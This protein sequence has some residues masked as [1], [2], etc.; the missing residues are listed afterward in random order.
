[1]TSKTVTNIN[2]K[3]NNVFHNKGDTFINNTRYREKGNTNTKINGRYEKKKVRYTEKE[4]TSNYKQQQ[5]KQK[6]D[7][8]EDDL[9]ALTFHSN[10][11]EEEE[12]EE[13]IIRRRDNR[14]LI[15]E[16]SVLAS[17][18]P[19]SNYKSFNIFSPRICVLTE[20]MRIVVQTL[21]EIH[22]KSSTDFRNSIR[23]KK[24]FFP[25]LCEEPE[26]DLLYMI[27]GYSKPLHPVTIANC[28][29]CDK[30]LCKKCAVIRLIS[31]NDYYSK[32]MVWKTENP[33][34]SIYDYYGLDHHNK[35]SDNKSSS[36]DKNN[37]KFV[38]FCKLCSLV[39]LFKK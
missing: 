22:K 30:L 4:V 28:V 14:I 7:E 25:F 19:N 8:K 11:R 20:N 2:N 35:N 34:N 33:A 15:N 9:I 12:E 36:S 6:Q 13:E 32:R 10:I 38:V 31:D 5:Q 24:G 23:D 17:A 1:M 37:Q 18:I 27:V 39:Y 29:H 16:A 3:N 21:Y 26:C